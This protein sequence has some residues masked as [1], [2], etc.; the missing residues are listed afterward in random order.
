MGGWKGALVEVVVVVG[1]SGCW[2]CVV[3]EWAG[4][5]YARMGECLRRGK[6]SE[7][8][9]SDESEKVGVW[10]RDREGDSK[11]QRGR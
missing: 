11:R 6:K 10:K 5:V 7:N 8:E 2:R 3:V 4:M 1:G 9:F